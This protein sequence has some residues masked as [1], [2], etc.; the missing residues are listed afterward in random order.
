MP[1]LFQKVWGGVW[2][3]A[4]LF[5]KYL[6]LWLHRVLVAAS[7]SSLQWTASPVMAPGLSCSV[8]HGILVILCACSVT[9]VGSDCLQPPGLQPTKAPLSMVFS[10][11]QYWSGFPSP[12]PQDLLDPGTEPKS[13]ALQ[14]DSLL[15]SYQ[16]SPLIIL[17]GIKSLSSPLQGRLL[18]NGPPGKFLHLY[19][20][21]AK[22]AGSKTEFWMA[23]IYTSTLSH[24]LLLLL[25]LLSRFSRVQLC[26]TPETA[27]HQAPPSLGFSRQEHWSGLPLPSPMH[28]SEKWKWSHSVMSDS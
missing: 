25:L 12:P 23:R 18:T 13:P 14:A 7:G 19:K 10:R 6:F 1:V 8:A 11:Q 4:F 3:S 26:A 28:E 16:E 9:S 20:W 5:F 2:D 22:A 21:Y 15:L 27:A 24:H 17:T